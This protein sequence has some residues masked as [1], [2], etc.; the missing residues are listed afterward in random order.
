MENGK[1]KI[2]GPSAG[3]AERTV[4]VIV[5]AGS[6]S[7]FGGAVPKQFA[8]LGG[9][10]LLEVTLSRF[11]QATRID[12]MVVVV[13]KERVA[14]LA[15]ALPARFPR[16]R[17]VVAGGATRQESVAAGVLAAGA[18]GVLVVHDAARPLIAPELIDRCI[19]QAAAHGACIVALPA[20]D[21]IKLVRD[22]AIVETVPR[23]SIWQAQT[24][25]AFH[26]AL[27]CRA[28][29]NARQHGISGTDEAALVEAL[30]VR[31]TVVPGSTRNIKV[32]TA[33]DLIVAEALVQQEGQP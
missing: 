5:A 13:A 19:M 9:R 33:E 3:G 27:L 1:S 18:C 20:H 25:Q 32:T 7:R 16:L 23:E 2:E 6:G 21:T 4:A 11:A 22:S 24:P 29:E 17:T 28:L 14:E 30:G 8:M 31:V 15:A 12:D 26:A 10:P